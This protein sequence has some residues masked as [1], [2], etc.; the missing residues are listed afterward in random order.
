MHILVADDEHDTVNTLTCILRAEGYTAHAV[1]SG[2]D[3]LV[4]A[5]LIRPDAII[6]DILIPG[7]SGYAVAQAIRNTFVDLRRPLMI[8]IS[9][10]W[11]E[12]PDQLVARQVGFDHYL[13]KPVDPRELL[14]LLAKLRP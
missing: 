6:L 9:G 12:T 1:Y 4:A 10:K 5:R 2:K 7:M 13:V 3:V 11:T 14:R 8:A